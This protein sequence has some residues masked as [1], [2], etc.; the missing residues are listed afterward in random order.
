MGMTRAAV[1]E[2]VKRGPRI[3]VGLVTSSL[4]VRGSRGVALDSR[5]LRRRL[6]WAYGGVP[7]TARLSRAPFPTEWASPASTPARNRFDPPAVNP[8]PLAGL[9]HS[10]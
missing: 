10:S 8:N 5:W 1:E 9:V 3:E 2:A 6:E 7:A 4:R